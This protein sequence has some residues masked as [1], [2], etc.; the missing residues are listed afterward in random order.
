MERNLL[1][2]ISYD[3]TP[4]SGWQRQPGRSTV[5]GEIEKA[6]SV[7]CAAQVK[8]DGTSRTD[9]GVHALGQRAG[10]SGGFAI[11]T[12]NIKFALNNLLPGSIRIK[13]V[14]EKPEGFHA[15]YDCKG[16]KY[17]Y[18]IINSK[19]KDPFMRNFCYY[20]GDDLDAAAMRKAAEYIKGEH[21][22]KCFQ[23]AGGKKLET[24]VRTVTDIEIKEYD[25]CEHGREIEIHVSGDGFL[26]NMVRIIAGTLVDVG[27][28][29]ID[30]DG[31][32]KIIE[33]RDRG[34]AGHTAPAGGLYLA[35]VY[36]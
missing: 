5:Q 16:K 34:N 13:K 6:L 2:T 36:Y 35:E 18:K 28:G 8:V 19:E 31:T 23:A 25:K 26:Y 3:G 10:F 12:G 33:G 22:F 20:V 24:T 11:P 9:A 27:R 7:L 14:E 4:F 29:K 32:K 1:L 30:P 21:D 17:I 15:R